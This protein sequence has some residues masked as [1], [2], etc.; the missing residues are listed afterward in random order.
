MATKRP[1]DP[2]GNPLGN[3]EKKPR[4]TRTG[5]ENKYD[6]IQNN[7]RYEWCEVKKKY[8]H[9]TKKSNGK[10][11]KRWSCSEKLS[12]GGFCK[13]NVTLKNPK[14]GPHGGG[15][16]K[17][18]KCVSLGIN[19]PRFSRSDGLCS[20]HNIKICVTDGCTKRQRFKNM[21]NE[22]SD[23][24]G[25]ICVVCSK[26]IPCKC[27]RNTISYT[28]K[29]WE[30]KIRKRILKFQS[31]VSGIADDHDHEL[32]CSIREYCLYLESF[33]TSKNGFN[34]DNFGSVW[35]IDHIVA[36]M[37]QDE[38]QVTMEIVNK[39]KHFKNTKPMSSNENLRKGNR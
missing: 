36:F 3:P 5:G 13:S 16:P 21:C 2:L 11:Q 20:T 18:Y 33:F 6:V 26:W 12:D 28:V 7:R 4:V 30:Q 19:P 25:N 1:G 24:K 29:T 17:C 39:R 38:G 37:N 15:K 34:W 27:D 35:Q 22:C 8:F 9:M 14:C 32:G 31:G 23:F 10:L